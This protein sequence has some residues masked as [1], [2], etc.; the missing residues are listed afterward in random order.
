MSPEVGRPG[1]EDHYKVYVRGCCVKFSPAEIN[2]FLKRSEGANSVDEVPLND[3]AQELTAKQVTIWPSKGKIQANH[4]SVKYAIL[5]KISV[6]NWAP[7]SH[8]TT[9]NASLARLLFAIGTKSQL[10]FGSYVFE[11]TLKHGESYAVKMPIAF[12]CL[13]TEMIISQHPDILRENEEESPKGSPLNFDYRLFVGTHVKDIEDQ[14]AKEAGHSG[15][16][17]EPVKE[18]ILSELLDTSKA[19]Q[20]TIRI[21]TAKKIRID[22]LIMQIQAEKEVVVEE[23][24]AGDAEEEAVEKDKNPADKE[25]GVLEGGSE[26]EEEEEA[27]DDESAEDTSATNT[28]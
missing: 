19:L 22:K 15:L 8:T 4:L 28:D 12:P 16:M 18:D 25:K 1:H 17:T 24:A 14:P 27:S 7:S 21:C 20:E 9:I 13:I 5:H 10:D 6:A 2:Q 11:Q 26:E 3:I 23:D